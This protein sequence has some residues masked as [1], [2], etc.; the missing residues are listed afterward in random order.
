MSG[1]SKVQYCWL[2]DGQPTAAEDAFLS[3]ADGQDARILPAPQRWG[4][5]LPDGPPPSVPSQFDAQGRPLAWPMRYAIAHWAAI[6]AAF[7]MV[8]VEYR[9]VRFQF[10]TFLEF[11]V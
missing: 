7:A 5:G 6:V 1:L 3:R 8:Y 2:P 4:G 9:L 10:M 11:H